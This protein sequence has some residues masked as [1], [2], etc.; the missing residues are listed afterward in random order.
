MT[1]MHTKTTNAKSMTV[2]DDPRWARIVARDKTADGH[3]WYSVATTGVY[4]RPSCPSRIANPRKRS[5]S[6]Q[7]AKRQGDRFQALQ[8]LQSGWLI[9]RMRECGASREGVP[10]Y[11]GERGRAI[12]GRPCRCRRPQPELLPPRVQGDHG[13]DAKGL[14]RR[15]PREEGPPGFGLRPYRHRGDLRCGL[16][17]QRAFLRE[18]DGHARHDPVAIP[19]GGA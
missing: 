2:A 1:A 3:L 6:R 10:D 7:P 12:A 14:W 15:P 9:D 17:F 16:Q 19:R 18:V 5:A 8:A 13:P 11:R 4:C